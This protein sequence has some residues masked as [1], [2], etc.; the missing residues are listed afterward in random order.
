MS[1]GKSHT[2]SDA[3]EYKSNSSELLLQQNTP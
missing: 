1:S 3:P 2:L